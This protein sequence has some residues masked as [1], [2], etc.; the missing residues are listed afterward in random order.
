MS[1]ESEV[2]DSAISSAVPAIV[3]FNPA[4][5]LPLKLTPSNF[6]SW[7]SQL[8]TLLLGLDLFSYIDG[9]TI[10]PDRTI[11]E[12]GV[13]KP[14]PAFQLW[15]R[16]DKLILH[17]LRCSISEGIYSFVSGASTSPAA[18]LILEKLY[19][20]S[21]QSRIIH[22]KGKLAKTSKGNRDILA[23]VNDLK[24]TAAELALIGAPVSDLDLI[25]YCLRGLGE[26]YGA[27]AAAIR[28]RGPGL[29]LEDLID[30]LVEYESDLKE[31]IKPPVPTA[32]FSQG[33]RYSSGSGGNPSFG[34]QQRGSPRGPSSSW[35][36]SPQAQVDSPR[37]SSP[38]AHLFFPPGQASPTSHNQRRPTVICQFC[39]RPGHSVRQCFKLFPEER[40][41]YQA[42]QTQAHHTTTS[43]PPSAPWLLDSAASHHVTPDLGNLSLY[44]DYNGP[45]EILVGDGTG[46][47]ITHIGS[48]MLQNS[49]LQLNDVLCAPAIK[50]KLISVAKLCRTNPILVEFFADCFVVKD[51]RTGAPLLKGENNGD[52]YELPHEMD[53]VHL[54]LVTTRTSSTSWHARFG[55][56]SSHSLSSLL[57]THSLPVASS[58]VSSHCDSCISN[59]SQTPFWCLLFIK[60]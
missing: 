14:N 47:K 5:Q 43:A 27:F 10:A 48:S 11:T 4:A 59:K 9:T 3:T 40:Q 41:A 37:A 7:R 13:A 32:F 28:A 29:V 31:Q 35:A 49:A 2:H 55:H 42:R 15:F 17:A 8:E 23:F 6:A 44:S 20:S 1:G 24:S 16:Q 51:L 22:L 53:T 12:N 25:V 54:A 56:P 46:L 33:Q 58:S 60:H 45:D 39:E 19:A 52:V 38:Q 30:S 50:R 36:Y 21:A 18:W 26:E 34:R 57:R